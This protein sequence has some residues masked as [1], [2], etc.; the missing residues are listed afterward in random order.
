MEE[1]V[2]ALQKTSIDPK[3]SEK[4]GNKTSTDSSKKGDSAN[5]KKDDE[6]DEGMSVD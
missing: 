2:K 3:D 6:D 5:S 4:S 1:F